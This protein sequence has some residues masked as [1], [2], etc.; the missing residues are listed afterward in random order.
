MILLGIEVTL[1]IDQAYSLKEKRKT[2]KSI[3]D[4]IRK[5]H[6]VAANEIGSQDMLNQSQLGFALVSQD[7]Q[8]ARNRLDQIIEEI[9]RNYPVEIIKIT[10]Y[11]GIEQQADYYSYDSL[12]PLF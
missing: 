2:I 11:E 3:A 6:Q 9:F 12:G 7:Y 8:T 1:V 10:W 4:R 5:R